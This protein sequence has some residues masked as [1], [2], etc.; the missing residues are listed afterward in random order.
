M[1][2][3]RPPTTTEPNNKTATTNILIGCTGSVAAIKVPELV[4]RF[5]QLPGG[6]HV[7]VVCTENARRFCGAAEPT[8]SS[9][10]SSVQVLGDADEWAAWRGRGDPVLHIELGRWADVLVVAPLDANTMAK[11]ANVRRS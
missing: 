6:C 7:R 1:E 10:L 5:A 9:V 3:P 4:A 2:P 8:P 11:M